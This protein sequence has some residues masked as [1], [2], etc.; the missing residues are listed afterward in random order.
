MLKNNI[1]KGI[2]LV[3]LIA[4]IMA[5]IILTTTAVVSYSSFSVSAK[6]R[7]FANEIYT[8]QKQVEDYKFKNNKY[9]LKT[10][11]ELDISDLDSALVSIF[12]SNNEQIVEGKVTLYKIDYKKLDIDSL[13]RGTDE[14]S[15]DIYLFSNE[16]KKVYYIEGEKIENKTYYYLDNELY[17]S[18][19]L[20]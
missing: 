7:A 19:K 13:V 8:L 2:T 10:A 14:N 18:L 20:K 15:N 16:S 9:P 17:E 5:I 3:A 1:K 6:K 4:T 11:K 12:N